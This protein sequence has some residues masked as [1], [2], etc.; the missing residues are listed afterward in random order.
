VGAFERDVWPSP[1][2]PPPRTSHSEQ[3]VT[4]AQSGC[5]AA[6]QGSLRPAGRCLRPT[7]SG[8]LIPRQLVRMYPGRVGRPPC[9]PRIMGTGIGIS[10]APPIPPKPLSR[11]GSRAPTRA[12]ERMICTHIT[13]R[14]D[15]SPAA[16]NRRYAPNVRLSRSAG[17]SLSVTAD[18][19]AKGLSADVPDNRAITRQSGRQP[20]SPERLSLPRPND[21]SAAAGGKQAL[22][23]LT[24]LRVAGHASIAAALRFHAAAQIAHCKRH[25]VLN[26]SG[27]RPASCPAMVP[28]VTAG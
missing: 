4:P 19:R 27:R 23:S 15:H 28:A 25:E 3:S 9:V 1:Q 20:G 2:G 13:D 6:S 5:S 24:S 14:T 12:A 8:F 17:C 21:C 18:V 16:R 7:P 11:T 10:L 26:G 22:A